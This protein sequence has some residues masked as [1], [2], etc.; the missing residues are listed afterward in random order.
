[1]SER[2]LICRSVVGFPIV[3]LLLVLLL[4]LL[5]LLPLL[6]VLLLLLLRCCCNCCYANITAD[7]IT[8]VNVFDTLIFITAVTATVA[9]YAVVSAAAGG[10]GD[11]IP[12]F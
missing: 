5:L 4:V 10:G 3:L 12:F 7:A 6:L 2:Y 9:G 8:A 1:M 11:A